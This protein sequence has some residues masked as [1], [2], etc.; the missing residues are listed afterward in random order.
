[1]TNPAGA[2]RARYLADSIATASP[3]RL[4]VMLYDRLVLDITQG[5]EAIRR[6]DR[7]V[8]SERLM[9]A[10]EILG[11]LLATLDVTAWDGAENMASLYRFLLQELVQA[12]IK[13]DVGKAASCRELTSE[14]RDAWRE[15]AMATGGASAPGSA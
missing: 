7:S 4:L 13:Q 9:H 8:S 11:E 10:Q 14:L 15:A 5:E 12:N 6:G 2:M 3:A 1:M